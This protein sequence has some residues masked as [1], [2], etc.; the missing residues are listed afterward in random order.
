MSTLIP[1]RKSRL[2]TKRIFGSE[3]Y[4]LADEGSKGWMEKLA[5]GFRKRGIKA[6]LVPDTAVHGDYRLYISENPAKH[7]GIRG[8][9]KYNVNPFHKW[10]GP[11]G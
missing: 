10:K 4:Y 2:K 9:P 8:A 6:R 3:T 11:R 7:R 5:D 1:R